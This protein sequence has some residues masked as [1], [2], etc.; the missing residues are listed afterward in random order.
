MKDPKRD[1][2]SSRKAVY[3]M[4]LG[5][6]VIGFLVF[7]S[8]FFTVIAG[9]GGPSTFEQFGTQT[10]SI[11]GRGFIGILFIFIGSLL[12]RLGSRGAAGSGLILDPRRTRRD[13]E[14]W[15]RAAGGLLGDAMDEAGFDIDRD[16][17]GRELPFDEKLRRLDQLRKENL[18]TEDEYQT[19][20][21][22]ILN[23][24]W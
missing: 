17:E 21:R 3:Y 8:V 15:G 16:E 23:Q 24:R 11:A 7:G 9:F 10:T 12:M 20:R 18:I 1:I 6:M 4:G 22:E 2:S 13:L 5:L 14:P 19:K